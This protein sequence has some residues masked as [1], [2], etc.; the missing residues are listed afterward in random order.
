MSIESLVDDRKLIPVVF[1]NGT[2]SMISN[3]VARSKDLAPYAGLFH[4]IVSVDSTKKFKPAPETYRYLADSIGKERSQMNEMWL[5]S[6]NPFDVMGAINV[7]MK[8][9]WVNQ[10]GLG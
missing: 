7:G 9:A 10:A 2:T 1:S 5:I 3:S 6:G 8:A 4:N